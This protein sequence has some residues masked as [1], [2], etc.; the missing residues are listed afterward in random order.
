TA[1]TIS[2][3]AFCDAVDRAYKTLIK[4]DK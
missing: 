2:S 4:E 1:A 3:R